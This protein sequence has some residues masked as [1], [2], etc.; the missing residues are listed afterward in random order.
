MVIC[1][2]KLQT[3]IRLLLV[4]SLAPIFMF[5]QS[6]STLLLAP[7]RLSE[8]D[9]L[10]RDLSKEEIKVI[11]ATRSPEAISNQPFSVWVITGEDILRN[12]FVTLAD[13]L[14][15]APG[16]RVSQ[17]GNAMEGETFLMRGLSGN[18]YVKILINDMPV[19]PAIALGMPIGAQLPIRQAERIEVLYG[20]AGAI[21]GEEACAGVINIILKETERPVFTQADLSFA[22][23]GYTSLDL[24]FGGKLGRDKNIFRYSIYGSSTVRDDSDYFYDEE[25][26][27]TNNYLELGLDTSFYINNDN[28]RGQNTPKDS[29]ARTGVLPHE[30]R[31]FGLNMTWR[32]L[33]FSYNR[34]NRFDRSALGLNP[35]A[36]SYANPSNRLAE[37]IENYTLGFQ[38]VKN[39]RTTQTTFSLETYQISNTS[40]TTYIFDRL[41]A[42]NYLIR[43]QPLQTDSARSALITGIFN[44]YASDERFAVANGYDARVRSKMNM[45]FNSRFKLDVGGL[46]HLGGGAPQSS[47]FPVPVSVGVDGSVFPMGPK[48]ISP[49]T[50]TALDGNFFAQADWHYKHV[51]L[52]GGTAVN[53]SVEQGITLAPRLGILYKIDSTWSLRFTGS[54]GFRHASMFG[55]ANTFTIQPGT[56]LQ[57]TAGSRD[58]GTEKFY[59]AEAGLRYREGTIR[60]E[61]TFFLQ[62]A[63]R[64]YRPGYLVS[65]PGIVPSFSYGYK[66]APGLAQALWGVQGLFKSERLALLDIGNSRHRAIVTGRSEL[67]VQYMKGKEWFGYDISSTDDLLN[68]PKWTIQFRSFIKV[69]KNVEL[70]IAATKLSASLSK[71]VLYAD[72]YRLQ[73]REERLEQYTTWDLVARAYLSNHFLVYCNFTNI[74][75][76]E[77]QGLDATGTQDDLLYNPQ[78]GRVF[79]LG[80]NYNM[81]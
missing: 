78:P 44:W 45:Y 4:L 70:V 42:A 26:F 41:S 19:K 33:Q 14:K 13:V 59:A 35:L 58:F 56:G 66:N 61:I 81:N 53:V 36:V 22:Q 62:Q 24:M 50:K 67:Y 7:E 64:L 16:I 38:R 49:A 32:G 71:S 48:T 65:E 12:G 10:F 17:P 31:M 23:N 63:H 75:N 39:K 6:D 76:R 57:V 54:S 46:I 74:F 15:A 29:I 52:I 20:P 80:V 47:Y 77:Y 27:N 51:N 2:K 28:Y 72:F 11:S 25:L 8:R 55:Y 73:D 69:N 34:F 1:G 68:Q 9:I 37:T 21:Y 43:S 40:T 60:S 79:R 18:Q 5:A 3:V 30:S